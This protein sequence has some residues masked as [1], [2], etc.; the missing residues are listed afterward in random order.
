MRIAELSRSSG[1]P[2]PTIKYYL[3]EGLLDRGAPSAPN[4]ADYDAEH[5]RRLRLIRALREIGGLGIADVRSVVDALDNRRMPAHQLI[6]TALYA[7]G[8]DN[9]EPRDE[10]D[11]RARK[12][13]DEF[14]RRQGWTVHPTAPARAMLADA[15]VALRRLGQ[16]ATTDLF[17]PYAGVADDLAAWELDFLPE[18]GSRSALVEAAVIGSVVFE[19]VLVALRRLAHEHHSAQRFAPR[20]PSAPG[21]KNRR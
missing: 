3:R 21:R 16:R 18:Q 17:A 7:L 14:L 6:G 12:E 19:S 11:F 13:V 8:P 2:V 20:R 15:L 9:D 5:V 4:Q 10:E 1:V